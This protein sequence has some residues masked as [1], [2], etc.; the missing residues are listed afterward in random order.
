[1]IMQLESALTFGLDLNDRLGG[2]AWMAVLEAALAR[3]GE[4]L[5]V[6]DTDASILFADDRAVH[7]LERLGMGP[8]RVPPASIVELVREQMVTGDGQRCVVVGAM[9]IE[10]A[11]LRGLAGSAQL[12]IFLREIAP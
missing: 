9:V 3:R 2:R 6:C 5:A 10:L 7:L 4:G 11:V 8:D 1:M 12:A